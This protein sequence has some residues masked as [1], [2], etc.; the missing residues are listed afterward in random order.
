LRQAHA[1]DLLIE[2]L[3]GDATLAKTHHPQSV[4]LQARLAKEVHVWP[5]PSPVEF[6]PRSSSPLF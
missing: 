3:E 2:Q 5:F 6:L 4:A 1:N